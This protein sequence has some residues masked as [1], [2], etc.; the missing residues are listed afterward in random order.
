MM[1]FSDDLGKN[2]TLGINKPTRGTT[3]KEVLEHRCLLVVAAKTQIVYNI[4]LLQH[5]L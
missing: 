1:L 4:H 2:E 3:N 5:P